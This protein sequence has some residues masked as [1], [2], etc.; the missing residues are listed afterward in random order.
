[1]KKTIKLIIL[2]LI[3]QHNITYAE[4][5]NYFLNLDN[6]TILVVAKK[7]NKL[8]SKVT[9]SDIKSIKSISITLSP[10]KFFQ[11]KDL[12][13]F[14][15][16]EE[17]YIIGNSTIFNFTN[18]KTYKNFMSNISSISKLKN[19]K[20][21]NLSNIGL[22]NIE[23]LSN[24]NALVSLDLSK[25]AIK[26]ILPLAKLTSL[27]NLNL[28]FNTIYN[29][30]PLASLVHLKNLQLGA[31]EIVNINPLSSLVNLE[32]L[33]LSGT[34]ITNI[35]SLSYLTKLRRLTLYKLK[36]KN[37]SLLKEIKEKLDKD[38]FK[39]NLII[40]DSKK[41]KQDKTIS[42]SK[43]KI[44]IFDNIYNKCELVNID[45]DIAINQIESA[46]NKYLKFNF[47]N[48]DRVTIFEYWCSNNGSNGHDETFLLLKG[49]GFY[50]SKNYKLYFLKEKE[51]EMKNN[52]LIN[53]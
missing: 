10:A 9:T 53:Q 21:L 45:K 47:K 38:I 34:D 25:N 13:Y 17:L 35:S 30:K 5:K 43:G 6:N 14:E 50:I 8:P 40:Y 1:M 16:L 2:S 11:F 19:L 23:F 26:D 41:S 52:L 29:L 49:Q 31:N 32:E 39:K 33:G 46:F 42:T 7:L 15:S 44:T 3:I 18:K 36:I 20:I 48:K 28:E 22:K 24:L 27:V 4:S 51:K 12:E 37:T